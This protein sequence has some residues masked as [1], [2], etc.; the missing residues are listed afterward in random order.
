LSY[1]RDVYMDITIR[2]KEVPEEEE[3]EEE[4]RVTLKRTAVAMG[5]GL[6]MIALGATVFR[7]IT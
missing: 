5:L 3:K 7:E 6:A 2:P 1:V 4:R